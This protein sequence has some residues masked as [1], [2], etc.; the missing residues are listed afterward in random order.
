MIKLVGR[1]KICNL[2]SSSSKSDLDEEPKENTREKETKKKAE[3]VARE[4]VT[5]DGTTQ[6]RS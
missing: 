6:Q 2:E 4:E 5:Q 3:K 1:G